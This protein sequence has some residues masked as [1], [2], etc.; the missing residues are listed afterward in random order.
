[1]SFRTRLSALKEQCGLSRPPPT[2]VAALVEGDRVIKVFKG[3]RWCSDEKMT[4]SGLPSTCK[5]YVGIDLEK[6]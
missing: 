2:I 3:G 5:V 6:V 1:M 4:V